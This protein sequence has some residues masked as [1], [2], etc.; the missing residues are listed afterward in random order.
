MATPASP[1][2]PTRIPLLDEKAG[3]N[4][5][6]SK[7]SSQE[8]PPPT[9][10][11][12][13]ASKNKME[14]ALGSVLWG[15]FGPCIPVIAVTSVLLTA[16]LY[17]RIPNDHVFLHNHQVKTSDQGLST[18]HGIQQIENNGGN[19]AYYLYHNSITNPAVLH[20]ISSWTAKSK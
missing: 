14:G 17:H 12:N 8:S 4:T 6:A 20:M 1:M 16:V 2:S 15:A 7:S 3:L 9:P 18:L 19:R 5:P 13:H 10:G 11:R